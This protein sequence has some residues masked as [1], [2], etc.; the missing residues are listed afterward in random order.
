MGASKFPRGAF[1]TS[2]HAPEVTTPC[3]SGPCSWHK[4]NDNHDPMVSPA[5]NLRVLTTR[6]STATKGANPNPEN[7]AHQRKSRDHRG[8]QTKVIWGTTK[9]S[10]VVDIKVSAIPNRWSEYLLGGF[11]CCEYIVTYFIKQGDY[12]CK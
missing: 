10:F 6:N 9:H 2:Q 5:S 7:S 11:Y 1:V 3:L 8:D 12:C 4:L